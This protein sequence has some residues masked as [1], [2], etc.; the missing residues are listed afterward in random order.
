M[1]G[2]SSW[3]ATSCRLIFVGFS[4]ISCNTMHNLAYTGPHHV[5]RTAIQPNCLLPWRILSLWAFHSLRIPQDPSLVPPAPSPHPQEGRRG[6]APHKSGEAG[7]LHI[8]VQCQVLRDWTGRLHLHG[9][10]AK[11]RYVISRG[12][13]R[14]LIMEKLLNV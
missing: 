10:F 1:P 4:S 8:R 5:N 13:V 7:G 3:G 2:A 12:N 14:L 9:G 11:L 6:R